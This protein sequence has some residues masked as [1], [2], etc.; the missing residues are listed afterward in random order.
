MGHVLEN[1]NGDTIRLLNYGARIVSIRLMLAGGPREVVLGLPALEDYLDDTLYLGCTV[2]RYCNRIA[3]ARFAIGGRNFLLAANEG[4]NLLH[5]GADGFNQRFWDIVEGA[6]S[7]CV[8]FRLRSPHGDQGF[9]GSIVA[10][11]DFEWSDDRALS[12][13]Y[14]AETDRATH[15]NLT[16]HAYFNLDA[17]S[18]DVLEHTLSIRGTAITE[19]APD[20]LPTG[21]IADISGSDLDLQSPRKVRRIVE[22][23]DARVKLAR[24][25]DF[26]YV[27]DGRG[28]RAELTSGDSRLSLHLE[29]TCPGLQLYTGQHLHEPFRPFAGLCLEPQYFPDS[30]NQTRFPSTL[31]LP[32]GE[33]CE[34]TQYIFRENARDTPI[35]A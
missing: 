11:A 16:N 27:S 28:T 35:S 7:R 33:F 6:T 3:R 31:L 21:T 17:T 25:A 12:V 23:N 5:G 10:R 34:T 13:T 18:T 9:P 22:S 1:R 29:S 20:L 26:N 30:P 15:V 14:R 19:I 8:S 4:P 32:G 24:G 2:G